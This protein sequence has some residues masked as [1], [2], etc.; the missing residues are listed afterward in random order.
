ML[1]GFSVQ[2]RKKTV[3]VKCLWL[4]WFLRQRNHL[5]DLVE[6]SGSCKAACKTPVLCT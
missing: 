3:R 2:M 1:G 4:C 5:K 6:K